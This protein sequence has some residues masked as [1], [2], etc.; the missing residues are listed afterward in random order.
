MGREMRKPIFTH[1]L[2][3]FNQLNGHK[4]TA[5]YSPICKDEDT[6]VAHSDVF[7]YIGCDHGKRTVLDCPS[8][9]FFDIRSACCIGGNEVRIGKC[10]K[11]NS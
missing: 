5:S 8:G 7:K 9:S 3:R 11:S 2:L 1:P 10:A 6:M 4:I